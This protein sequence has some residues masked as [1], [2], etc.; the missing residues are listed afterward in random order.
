MQMNDMILVSVD[1]HVC[2]PPDMWDRH[3]DR[4]VEGPRAAAGPQA[5]RQRRLGVRG[6]ADP[7]RRAERRG[8]PAPRGVRD[9][10]DGALA[11]AARLLRH[12]R[13]HRRHERQRRARLAL[14]PDG[15]GLRRRAVRPPG[16]GR[17]SRARH[18][19]A[20]RLQRLAHRRVVRQVPR[21]LHPAGDPAHLG[22]RGDG[23]RGAARRAGRAATPSPSPTTPAG[24]AIR[25]CTAS[26]GI[27]SGRPA[28]TRAR[29]SASTSARARA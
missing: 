4:E 17:Q 6:P 10:A 14:L 25:A 12:R 1:D 8:G 2:E 23:P 28:P 15:A 7:Q 27:R 5:G 22:P 21:P 13:A 24:S 20:A 16:Q 9:G 29:S 3:V 18:H 26:T 11:A 19:H